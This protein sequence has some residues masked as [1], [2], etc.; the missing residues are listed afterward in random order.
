MLGNSRRAL[1]KRIVDYDIKGR[2]QNL[3]EVPQKFME[4]SK[5]DDVTANDII[6]KKQLLLRKKTY[7]FRIVI[8]TV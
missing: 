7:R 2:S 1:Q 6:Q 5:A 3:K 8:T 4:V